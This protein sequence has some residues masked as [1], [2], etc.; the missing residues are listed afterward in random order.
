MSDGGLRDALAPTRLRA[1]AGSRSYERG[2]EYAAA[3]LVQRLAVGVDSATATVTGSAP[4]Q[5]ALRS[6]PDGGLNGA[7]TCPMGDAG[8]FCKHCVAVGLA[9]A[10]RAGA[11]PDEVRAY[12][13]ERPHAELVELVLDALGP[14]SRPP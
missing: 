11:G 1:L 10:G 9:V 12:L 4:Y 2:E 3:G 8:A 14:R 13:A 5:V 7:C 6:R